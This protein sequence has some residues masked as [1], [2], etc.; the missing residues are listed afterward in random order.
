MQASWLQPGHSADVAAMLNIQL[1]SPKLLYCVWHSSSNSAQ[2]LLCT[3]SAAMGGFLFGPPAGSCGPGSRLGSGPD[4]S[5]GVWQVSRVFW[6]RTLGA[7]R[8]GRAGPGRVRTQP[9]P[10]ALRDSTAGRRG[11]MRGIPTV[12]GPGAAHSASSR[13]LGVDTFAPLRRRCAA[14][15]GLMA[16]R[17]SGHAGLRPSLLQ[18]VCWPG[19]GSRPPASSPAGAAGCASKYL[20]PRQLWP[21]APPLAPTRGDRRMTE[22]RP[23]P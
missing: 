19:R 2:G 15:G 17:G 23:P 12:G 6:L 21:S 11:Q 3:S 8:P 7:G 1:G 20:A 16:Q 13:G 4:R 9:G 22:R 10:D 14:R 18:A 5:A